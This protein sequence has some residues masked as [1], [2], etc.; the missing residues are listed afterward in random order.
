MAVTWGGA[1]REDQVARVDE[2]LR[3]VLW[4][5]RL[6]RD[7]GSHTSPLEVHRLKGRLVLEG[8]GVK[9][10]QGVREIFDMVDGLPLASAEGQ[11]EPPPNKIVLIGRHLAEYDVAGSLLAAVGSSSP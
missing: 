9:V 5:N 1:L 10:V 8:G 3:S 7:S 2:W 4:D 6:P 11:T